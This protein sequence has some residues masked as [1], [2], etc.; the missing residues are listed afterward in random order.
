ML[1]ALWIMFCSDKV[2]SAISPVYAIIVLFLLHSL[3]T[4]DRTR[5][6]YWGGR[7]C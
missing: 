5:E 6:M 7:S 1:M 3:M 2:F 4:L